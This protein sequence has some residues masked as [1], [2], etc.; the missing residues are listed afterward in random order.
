MTLCFGLAEWLLEQHC[1]PYRRFINKL[2]E[3]FE[4]LQ[5]ERKERLVEVLAKIL[6]GAT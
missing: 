3:L 4:D 2:V 1:G 6:K 5:Y